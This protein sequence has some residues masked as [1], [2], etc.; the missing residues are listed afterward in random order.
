LLLIKKKDLIAASIGGEPATV[1][2][3]IVARL[4]EMSRRI[5]NPRCGPDFDGSDTGISQIKQCVAPGSVKYYRLMPNYFYSQNGNRKIRI[6]TQGTLTTITVCTSRYKENPR[7]NT[8]IDK[9]EDLE[10]TQTIKKTF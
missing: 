9:P 6:E 8:T 3:P 10:C 4:K 1:V 7:S 2:K 5:I